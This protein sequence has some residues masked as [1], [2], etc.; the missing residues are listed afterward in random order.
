MT[1]KLIELHTVEPVRVPGSDTKRANFDGK[2]GLSITVRADQ[3]LAI[4][5][6]QDGRFATVVQLTNVA[7]YVLESSTLTVAREMPKA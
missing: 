3:G 4:I 6:S 2:D 1:R 5:E 7:Y